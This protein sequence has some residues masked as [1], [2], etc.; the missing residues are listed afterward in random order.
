MKAKKVFM[1]ALC[2]AMV[3]LMAACGGNQPEPTTEA[4]SVSTTPTEAQ[5]EAPAKVEASLDFEDGNIGF[6]AVY[7]GMANAD[8]STMEV[9][10]YNGS[11]ALKITNGSGKVPYIALDAASVLG[12]NIGKVASIEMTMGIENPDGEFFACSGDVRLWAEKELSKNGHGWSVYLENKNPKNAVISLDT[13]NGEVLS[14]DVAPVI[15]VTLT[16]DNGVAAD[17]ANAN[18]FID[19][20][21]FLDADGNLI[22][23]DSSAQFTAPKGFGGAKDMSN[24]QYLGADAVP[25]EGMSGI[26]GS[27][28]GQNGVAMTEDFI[29]A[30][31]PG[32]VI[33]IEYASATGDMWIVMPDA[34]AGWSRIES[35]TAP[36]NGSVC[37]IS[38]EQIAAVCGEDKATWGTKLQFESS[39][40]WEVFS[41]SVA[42]SAFKNVK[43]NV[44]LEGFAVTGDGWAQAGI[45][46][47]EDMIAMM[48]PGSVITVQY[49]SDTGDMWLV[50]PDAAAGWN[51]IESQTAPC[52]GNICQITY[53]QIAA[54]LGED[55]STWG[56]RLQ[57]EASGAW[58]V[59]AVY[60]G[61]GV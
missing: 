30:L 21:R 9:V 42:K 4:T 19:D 35:Q 55:S 3:L 39:G 24:L 1:L 45:D 57:C 28:W 38:Y 58:E 15:V 29:A 20:I 18:L 33:E 10:D 48:V 16:T 14:A 37:Q 59:F 13:A 25:L 26:T 11:K 34:A 23:A 17:K 12:E 61:T 60:I 31:V 50:F 49:A 40:D 8:A 41:A 43:G 51:R 2:V 6:L 52:D 53:E 36:C 7:D 22:P 27:G 32:S 56:T 47:T 54:V 46:L 5:Q 44:A